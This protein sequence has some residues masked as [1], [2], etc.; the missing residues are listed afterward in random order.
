[1]TS[2]ADA[3]DYGFVITSGDLEQGTLNRPGQIRVDKV[4]TL[5]QSIVVKS[6]GRVNRLV[7]DR[8]RQLLKE[9]T[10]EKP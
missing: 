8:I 7:L 10:N 3:S 9:L 1:M 5:A 6:F 4:Y 2:H